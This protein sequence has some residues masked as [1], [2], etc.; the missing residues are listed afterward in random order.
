MLLGVW[1]S[2]PCPGPE[3]LLAAVPSVWKVD[4]R[5]AEGV[6][7]SP[8][9]VG[10]LLAFA[11]ACLWV[12]SVCCAVAPHTSLSFQ[13]TQP[14]SV[15]EKVVYREHTVGNRGVEITPRSG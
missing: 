14:C 6:A 4:T 9:P 2:F 10:L 8:G 11:A 3:G 5:V 1:D 13:L 15:P 7:V 12:H